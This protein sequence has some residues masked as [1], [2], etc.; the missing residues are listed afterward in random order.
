MRP[1]CKRRFVLGDESKMILSFDTS[2]YTTSACLF[3]EQEGIVWQNRILLHPPGNQC[4]LR[5]SDV[6]FLHTKNLEVLLDAM[7]KAQIDAV[8]ASA[9]PRPVDGSYMPCFLVGKNLAKSISSILG[10][11]FA[12]FSHQE[13]HIMA[14]LYSSGHL[15][16]LEKEFIAFHISGGTS[17]VL[18]VKTGEG[19]FLIESIG[20]SLDLHAGQLIDRIGVML[21]KQFPCGKAI[22]IMAN[23]CPQKTAVKTS[24][25]G[26][27]FHFSGF[28][29]QAKKM[30]EENVDPPVIAKFAL[31]CVLKTIDKVIGNIRSD[32]KD[33][34]ILLAGG[35]MSN[36]Y[37]AGALQ[38]KY[39][40]LYFS[41]PF[42]SSDHALGNAVLY[43]YLCK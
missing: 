28:E 31:D 14:A 23:S 37:I 6:V 26:Y 39:D 38:S 25:K 21:G 41:D 7:P 20:T 30:L 27:N 8:V 29:N 18:L 4:G 40:H 22:E 16:L 10:C 12:T 35:V 17:D 15:E 3:D 9:R 32:K 2:N 33:I 42:Y 5:Q 11:Q 24:V 19:G 1:V 34:P 13:N 36:R 43:H